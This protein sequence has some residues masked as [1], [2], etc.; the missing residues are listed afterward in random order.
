MMGAFL[1]DSDDYLRRLLD[2]PAGAE[3][4]LALGEIV[5]ALSRAAGYRFLHLDTEPQA[6][7][8]GFAQSFRAA[9]NARSPALAPP[10][11][12]PQ[13]IRVMTCH[14]AKGLEF[15]Y[16]ILAGQTL[17]RARRAYDWLPPSLMPSDQDERDQADAL[18][19]VGATRAQRAPG[20][21]LRHPSE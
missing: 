18:F 4:S 21:H 1:F 13:A 2:Q 10:Q 6:S 19:F 11:R 8:K 3:R 5:T 20:R 16:V 15:P 9:L 7:R 14:A 17:S 12:S